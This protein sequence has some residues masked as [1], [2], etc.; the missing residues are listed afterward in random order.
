MPVY[1]LDPELLVFPPP[2]LARADGLLA[3]GGDLSPERLL[4]AYQMGIFPWYGPDEPILWWAPDPRLV[5][6]PAEFHVS[7]RLRRTLRQGRFT[8]SLNRDFAAVIRACAE[9]PRRGQ[10]GSWLGEE[11]ITAYCRLHEMG[12]AHSVECRREGELVGGIYGVALGKVFFGESMFSREANASK[13][14]LAHLV[15]LMRLSGGTMID[16]QV[17]SDHLLRLGARLI[18]GRVFYQR[19]V[20]DIGRPESGTARL[21]SGLLL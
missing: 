14:A 18:P 16:C 11:M 20:L 19:L 7:R 17:S 15:E 21:P 12:Y 3:V 6:L 9:V 2:E 4:L 13:A 8:F 10:E 1:Q 5:L